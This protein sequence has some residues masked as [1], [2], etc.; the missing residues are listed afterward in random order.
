VEFEFEWD[1]TKSERTYAQRGI[2][3]E[4]ASTVF[5]DSHRIHAPARSTDTEQRYIVVG[6]AS[7]GELL[8][9]VY[10]WRQYG[11]Q[12]V[13]R[14]ISARKAREKERSRYSRLHELT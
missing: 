3:F 14:I 9:V 12:K 10:T 8:T 7:E 13:C 1:Q 2:L 5:Y 4:A 6:Q 11:N